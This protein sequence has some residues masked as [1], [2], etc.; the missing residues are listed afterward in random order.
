MF[1]TSS[2]TGATCSSSQR[3]CLAARNALSR[4]CFGTDENC[5]GSSIVGSLALWSTASSWQR[6]ALRRG[7]RSSRGIDYR[8]AMR[9]VQIA[10]H[11]DDLDRA[12]AWYTALLGT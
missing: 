4:C 3:A 7:G 5:V 8:P 11:A 9:L 10:Q 1:A 12:A 6:S 2:C